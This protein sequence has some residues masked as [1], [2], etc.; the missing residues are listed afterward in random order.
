MG[1]FDF[2]KPKKEADFSSWHAE[3]DI[4]KFSGIEKADI[5]SYLSRISDAIY[6][7]VILTP[8]EPLDGCKM[9]LVC[10]DEPSTF[11]MELRMQGETTMSKLYSKGGLDT[12]GVMDVLTK[13][14]ADVKAP[15]LDEWELLGNF[16][17]PRAKWH[18]MKL[19]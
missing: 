13:L 3:T 14:A 6:E 9:M 1:L 5:E 12:S 8:P 11:K 4:D 19:M 18:E 2:L 17:D 15:A 10:R 16:G 7:F